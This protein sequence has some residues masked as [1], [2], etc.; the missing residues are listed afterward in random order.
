M[1]LKVSFFGRTNDI[2]EVYHVQF[3]C[4]LYTNGPVASAGHEG[5][6]HVYIS[7]YWGGDEIK[8]RLYLLNWEKLSMTKQLEG[9]G[10][11]QARRTNMV[12]LVKLR[13]RV[14]QEPNRTK[15]GRGRGAIEFFQGKLSSSHIWSGTI[16]E[17]QELK[18]RM[19]WVVINGCPPGFWLDVWMG[20]KLFVHSTF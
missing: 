19:K 6:R 4:L 18:I 9:A 5:H 7:Q 16:W 13:W 17:S 14:L 2:S 3:T 1:E 11:R 10:L 12:L 20:T 15:Y 8:K